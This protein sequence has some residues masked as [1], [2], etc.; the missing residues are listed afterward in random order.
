MISSTE[1]HLQKELKYLRKTFQQNNQF[2]LRVINSIIS[3]ETAKHQQSKINSINSQTG[4]TTAKTVASNNTNDEKT[5]IYLT[6]P[7]AGNNGQKMISKLKRTV[8]NNSR[9]NIKLQVTYKPS[10][11]SS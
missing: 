1:S 6:L 4:I 2:P 11:L 9:N 3:K 5:K 7:F 8:E 10:K